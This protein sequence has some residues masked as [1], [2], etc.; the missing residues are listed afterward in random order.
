MN[1]NR[2]RFKS[3]AMFTFVGGVLLINPAFA[4]SNQDNDSEEA[5]TLDAMVVSGLR[6]SLE[7]SMNTKRDSAGVVDAI[8]A[9]DIG[10]FPDTNLAES[11]QRITGISIERRDG[12]GAQ[13]TARG[14]GPQFNLVTLNGRQI[15]GADGFS[16]GDSVTGGQGAGTRA[17]NFAQLASEAVS[18][19]E[20]YK[21]GR[22]DVP[23]GG[24]G[25]TID[26]QTDRP[27]YHEPGIRANF[28]LK[29]LYDDSA[30]FEND[31][32]PEASGIFSYTSDDKLWGVSLTASYQE[33]H[34]GSVQATEN[35]WNI[36][37]WTG[38]SSALRPGATVINPPQIGQLY[39]MPNDI[40]YAFSDFERERINAQ[41][42]LQFAPSDSLTLTLDYTY[43]TNEIAEDRGE[44]T[45]WLQRSN[46][47]THLE[48]D[49]GQAVA[50]PVY[51]RDIV[52]GKDFGFE[53]QRNEQKYNLKSLGFNAEWQV[54][55][56]FSLSFDAHDSKT[57]SLPNDPLT[58]GSA[59]FFSFAGTNC[60]TE[61]PFTPQATGSCPGGWA[62]E[63]FFN[64]G[65]PIA[66]RTF[67]PTVGDAVADV[68]GVFNPDFGPDDLA[69]QIMRIWYTR[70]D[71]EIKQGRI[72]GKFEFDEGRFTFGVDSSRVTA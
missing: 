68:G 45:M 62:Q 34:G 23:S 70:Q 10:K 18:A 57:A 69:S 25:A 19:V 38:T 46:S 22:A 12:E 48:F 64:T 30:P 67:Y 41:G 24:I 20:V 50:T 28:G 42:V 9:E 27:L 2:S 13:V 51:L 36:Q 52:G 54:T 26:I 61:N 49:T 44:Q 11:L 39:G 4:Q 6:N 59:T 56:A 60:V 65:L 14:F 66:S 58:G 53:Q 47:F 37:E 21:T 43:A 1:R 40:R 35:A 15:P 29:G 8:S 3:K 72:D 7:Q 5:R 55:D 33:R 71:T 17:F 63:F 31:I 16:N 32:T